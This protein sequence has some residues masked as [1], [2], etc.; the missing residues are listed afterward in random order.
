MDGKSVVLQTVLNV[1]K[2]EFADDAIGDDDDA[3]G[4]GMVAT[5]RTEA[6]KNLISEV[7]G[8]C[9]GSEIDFDAMHTERSRH[10]MRDRIFLTISSTVWPIFSPAVFTMMSAWV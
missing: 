6:A 2:I 10:S 3:T 7:N 8:I 9:S 4:D 5:N 1:R